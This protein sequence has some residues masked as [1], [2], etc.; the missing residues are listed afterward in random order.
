[1]ERNLALTVSPDS[2]DQGE[3]TNLDVVPDLA[4]VCSREDLIV[5]S[6]HII[7]RA[8]QH[9]PQVD[10]WAAAGSERPVPLFVV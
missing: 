2:L 7:V 6:I 9:C 5:S 3:R 4:G 8:M 1:M 10:S